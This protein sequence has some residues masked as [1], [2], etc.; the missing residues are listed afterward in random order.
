[1]G[2]GASK[3]EA[4]RRAA[5]F[6][7]SSD[8]ETDEEGEQESTKVWVNRSLYKISQGKFV[9]PYQT[10]SQVLLQPP[11]P[12][13]PNVC[14]L[15]TTALGHVSFA[16]TRARPDDPPP[17][18][19]RASAVRLLRLGNSDPDGAA[20]VQR[21]C[22]WCH[23]CHDAA[24]SIHCLCASHRVTLARVEKALQQA[25]EPTPV[26]ALLDNPHVDIS[27][28]NPVGYRRFQGVHQQVPPPAPLRHPASLPAAAR[29]VPPLPHLPTPAPPTAPPAPRLP[30][31]P[32]SPRSPRGAPTA[33]T[34]R[35][36]PGLHGL[37]R[38]HAQP[39]HRR[40]APA[41]HHPGPAR[42]PPRAPHGRL[43]G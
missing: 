23:D 18:M 34:A 32:R 25:T 10:N 30:H 8:D 1:M 41:A 13:R 28:T 26:E 3:T 4:E 15:Q 31:A 20:Q 5:E 17:E 36:A 7:L 35:G 12:G 42:P 37:C 21:G 27:S 2:G 43:Q 38:T 40:A 19:L 39:A 33:P 22:R 14:V 11:P 29:A 16:D 24:L 9:S 6:H